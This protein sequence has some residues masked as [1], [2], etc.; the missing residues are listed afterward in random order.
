MYSYILWPL[1]LTFANMHC[2][3]CILRTVNRPLTQSVLFFKLLQYILV[4]FELT[5][6]I[7]PIVDDTT[8]PRRHAPITFF[9]KDSEPS[10]NLPIFLSL[11]GRK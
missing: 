3:V 6:H 2:L 5:T 1:Q 8:R 7:L 4:G 9:F 11:F 10:Q